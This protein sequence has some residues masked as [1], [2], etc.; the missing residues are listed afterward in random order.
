[1]KSDPAYWS[2]DL[3]LVWDVIENELPALKVEVQRLQRE[4]S[5]SDPPNGV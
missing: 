5:S 1:M 4:L 2:I 3:P